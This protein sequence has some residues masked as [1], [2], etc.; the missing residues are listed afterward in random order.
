MAGT[1]RMER[2]Q[3]PGFDIFDI[4]P[5]TALQPLPPDRLCQLRCHQPPVVCRLDVFFTTALKVSIATAL[6]WIPRSTA[7]LATLCPAPV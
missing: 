3:T 1:E 2:C 5:L 6:P 4:I 7:L